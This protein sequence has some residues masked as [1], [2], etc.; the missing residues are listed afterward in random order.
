M[1]ISAG[2]ELYQMKLQSSA[3]GVSWID[4]SEIKNLGNGTTSLSAVAASGNLLTVASTAALQTGLLVQYT[5]T[6]VT[7]LTSGNFYYLYV[8]SSTTIGFATSAANAAADTLISISGTPSA[9]LLNPYATAIALSAT[10]AATN[11]LTVASTAALVTGQLVEYTGSGVTGLTSGSSY[12]VNVAS[13]TTVGFAT[14]AANALANTLITISGTPSP[15]LL[16]TLVNLVNPVSTIQPF[17]APNNLLFTF[18]VRNEFL[19]L[20]ITPYGTSPSVTV[21]ETF[22]TPLTNSAR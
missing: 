5:G 3:D 21:G 14:S 10:A 1:K 18:S 6:G 8:A 2:N 20:V 7:G 19:Q 9:G 15:G 22:I 13:G 17:T 11:L 12:Y 4:A 16:S